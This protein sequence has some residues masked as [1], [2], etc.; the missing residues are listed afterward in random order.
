M[1]VAVVHSYYSFDVPSGEN[2]IV[3]ESVQMLLAAGHDVEVFARYTDDLRQNSL[4]ALKSGLKVATGIGA[5]PSRELREFNPEI[6]HVHNLFPNFGT[7]WLREWRERLVATVHNFRP[8]CAN[9]LLFRD[10]HVC[11]DCPNGSPLSS[12]RHGCYRNSRAQT[13]PITA[14][15][16]GGLHH[17]SV[18]SESARIIV[19]SDMARDI[20][21]HFGGPIERMVVLANGVPVSQEFATGRPNGRWLVVGRLT[22]EKGIAQLAGYWPESI[23]LDIVGEGPLADE[24]HAT[25]SSSVHLLGALE[26]PKLLKMMAEYEG[27]VFPSVCL[28]MQPTAVIEAMAVGLPVVAL[29]GNAGADLVVRF[30]A[31]QVYSGPDDLENWLLQASRNRDALA[32]AGQTAYQRHFSPQQWSTK[33]EGLYTRVAEEAKRIEGS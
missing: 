27:L 18:F 30:G 5:S 6:V 11:L 9:G 10:G 7:R 3:D 28:E 19:L 8:I 24:I 17:D 31:G 14:R 15:N 13:L 32:S 1:R 4:Y 22:A 20:F 16:L 2:S 29:A 23:P 21:S 33:I 25:D 12:L 26:R